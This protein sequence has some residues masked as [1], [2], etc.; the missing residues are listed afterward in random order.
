MSFTSPSEQIAC[1]ISQTAPVALGILSAFYIV[2]GTLTP[3]IRPLSFLFHLPL[4][5]F[6]TAL[7]SVVW[8]IGLLILILGLIDIAEAVYRYVPV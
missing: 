2:F 8:G 6:L 3:E 4:V 5:L 7:C 1:W